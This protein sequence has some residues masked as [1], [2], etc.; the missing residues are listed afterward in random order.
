MVFTEMQK[1]TY[2]REFGVKFAY[3]NVAISNKIRGIESV[4]RK[5]WVKYLK[6]ES[7]I[8]QSNNGTS[9]KT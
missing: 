8:R 2:K 1:V 9:R 6:K 3:A 4:V 5:F 7:L